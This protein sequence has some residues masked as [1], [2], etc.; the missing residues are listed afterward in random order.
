MN[1]HIHLLEKG[2][3]ASR[4]QAIQF[5]KDQE[6]KDWAAAPVGAVHALVESLQQQLQSGMKQTFIRQDVV[7]IL[8]NMGSHAEPAIPQLVEL[9]RD[10]SPDSIREAA[11]ISLGKMGKKARGAVGALIDVLTHNR[12]NLVIVAVRAL[13]EI[14]C[15][16]QSVRSALV[17][18][19]QSSTHSK[20]SQVQV[21]MAMCK[22]KIEAA[23]LYKFLTSTLGGNQD[24]ALRKSAAEALAWCGKNELDVVPTLLS[25]ALNDKDENVQQIAEASL[26]QMR[27][28]HEKAVQICSQQLKDAAFAEAALRNSGALGVATLI[29]VLSSKDPTTREKAARTLGHLGEVAMAAVPGLTTVLRDKDLNVRLAAAKGLWNI[30][31]DAD[32]VVPVLVDLLK[33]DSKSAVDD[34]EPRRRFLQTVIEAL[35]RIGPPAKGAIPA[36]NAK[37][38]DP[39]RP[40]RESALN[41]IKRI[42][43]T[44]V[45]KE[46]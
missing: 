23:G 9:L 44:L 3:D 25:A 39:N 27:L 43:P 42:A 21:A 45:K 32:A 10:G 13:S 5:L 35:W 37:A 28:S 7:K 11:A 40:I 2:D 30:N 34:G 38:K 15:A 19:W 31:K 33:E 18:L 36:L 14:G 26:A 20:N 1:H 16:D 46:G 12:P 8:G 41:A 4:R 24:S 22:L 17:N 29:E 6:E